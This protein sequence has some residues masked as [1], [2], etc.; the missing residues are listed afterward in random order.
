MADLYDS[1]RVKDYRSSGATAMAI[2]PDADEV[3]FVLRGDVYVTSVKYETT[4]RV[5]NTDGQERVVA[6]SPDGKSLVYDSERDGLWR[7]YL[8]KV[9]EGKSFAYATDIEEELLYEGDAPAQQ[10]A[11]SPD[12]KKWRSFPTV[13]KLR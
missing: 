10:P 4:R 8:A 13:R 11:F 2:S 12:G 3:A 6:F 9:K 1:D 7:I 5:T